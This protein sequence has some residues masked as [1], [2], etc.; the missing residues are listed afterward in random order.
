MQP[1]IQ[2]SPEDGIEKKALAAVADIPAFEMNDTNRLAFH[3]Y[4]FLTG[5]I[6]TLDEALMVAQPRMHCTVKE[7]RQMISAKLKEMG[8]EE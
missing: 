8:L 6:S 5:S 7:A 2:P 1:P 4:L 3:V